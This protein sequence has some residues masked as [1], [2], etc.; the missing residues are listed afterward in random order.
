MSLEM[1][2]SGSAGSAKMMRIRP[3]PDPQDWKA[4]KHTSPVGMEPEHIDC[5]VHDLV[6]AWD[7]HSLVLQPP[8]PAHEKRTLQQA[9]Q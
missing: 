1:I 5:P 7:L 4:Q 9:E 2:R 8:D 6:T 3:D